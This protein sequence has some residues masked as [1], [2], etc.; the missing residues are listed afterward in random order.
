MQN[1][2]IRYLPIAEDDVSD[3]VDYLC[4][5][6]TEAANAFIDELERLENV[7]PM[8][9]E[10]GSLARNRRLQKKGYRMVAIGDYLLFY[11]LHDECIYIMRVIHG[12]RDYMSLL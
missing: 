8:F 12:K 10:S 11:T 4:E 5:Y 7:L 3:I 9:P 2:N 6:S 1:Y